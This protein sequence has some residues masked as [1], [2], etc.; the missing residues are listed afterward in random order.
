M[1]PWS[2]KTERFIFDNYTSSTES[3]KQFC[4]L[5]CT[6]VVESLDTTFLIE[7]VVHVLWCQFSGVFLLEFHLLNVLA[8]FSHSNTIQTHQSGHRSSYCQ[9]HRSIALRQ[10]QRVNMINQVV[11]QVRLQ[12]TVHE[13]FT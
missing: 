4:L 12:V 13:S 1:K 10:G 3:S 8:F 2:S 6:L 7:L 9:Y 11:S 5:K